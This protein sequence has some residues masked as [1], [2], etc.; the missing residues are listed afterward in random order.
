[1]QFEYEYEGYV[2]SETICAGYLNRCYLLSYYTARGD[3]TTIQAVY[4]TRFR[5][6]VSVLLHSA[7]SLSY[8]RLFHTQHDRRRLKF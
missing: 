7:R 6:P 4:A 5:S 2:R 1:M 3:L 8:R